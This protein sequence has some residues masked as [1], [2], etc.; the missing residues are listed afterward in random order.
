MSGKSICEFPD[1]CWTPP[2]T[3]GTPNGVPIPYPNTALASDTTD[4]STSVSIG[5]QEVMLKDAS[6]F[7]K[8]SGDEAGKAPQKGMMTTTTTGT[9]YFIAWSMNVLVESEN[10]VRNLDMT[11]HNHG[12]AN[13]TGL[14][15]TP[16][17]A[18]VATPPAHDKCQLTTYS[19]NNCPSGTTPHHLVPDSLFK[20]SG[21]GP[22]RLPGVTLPQGDRGYNM[23]LC[24]C[25]TG[26]DKAATIPDDQIRGLGLDPNRIGIDSRGVRRLNATLLQQTRRAVGRAA[27]MFP[28]W[29]GASP[30][31]LTRGEHGQ[32]HK[33]FDNIV[34]AIGG[35]KPPPCT[36]TATFREQSELAAQMCA[37]RFG[38]NEKEVKD[39]LDNHYRP[40][41][42]DDNTVMRSSDKYAPTNPSVLGN[43]P[44]NPCCG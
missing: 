21:S 1:V 20:A 9:V 23:G 6:H 12:S 7:K 5:G 44:G 27:N 41:G 25:L 14:T 22:A 11:T 40:H 31:E 36:N 17:V 30:Y 24:I 8:G 33:Q 43:V 19:P 18:T 29:Q 15:P 32:F 3:P 35:T 38:C 26:Q 42:V 10:V 2:Q 37:A 28:G 4:G 34:Q 16:H 39:Q 13:A